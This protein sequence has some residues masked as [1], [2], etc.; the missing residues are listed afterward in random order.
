[1]VCSGNSGTK[2]M[3]IGIVGPGRVGTALGEAFKRAGYEIVGIV[4]RDRGHATKCMRFTQCNYWSANPQS[5]ARISELII[6]AVPDSKI[7][8]IAS[9]IAPFISTDTILVHTSGTLES[10]ILGAKHSLSMHPVASF[11]GDR[12]PEGTYFG[13]ESVSSGDI[14]I[15]KKLV[16][17]IGGIPIVISARNK[18]LYHA[19]LNF[20]A[21]YI[22][23]LLNTG[24]KLL[25]IS[26]VQE[27]EKVI[28]SLASSTLKNAQKFG[29]KHSLTGPIERK[30]TKVVKAE[31][32]AIKE[33]S[34]ENLEIYKVLTKETQKLI[35]EQRQRKNGVNS[36]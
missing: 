9:R 27:P 11:A 25:E 35:E 14:E 36:P 6:I 22:L 33:K 28:L 17:S 31:L 2:K 21:A 7:G 20:G 5:L 23:A 16:R 29:I 34:P 15:G 24:R 30:D 18:P 19:A 1:M 3:K 26:G 12:L 10:S 32:K 13:I 4:S 8:S